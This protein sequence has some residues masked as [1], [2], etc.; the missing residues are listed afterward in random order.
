MI[1]ARINKAVCDIRGMTSVAA[2]R[3]DLLNE[4]LSLVFSPLGRDHAKLLPKTFNRWP[5]A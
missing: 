2:E 1:G 4:F 3:L 5:G